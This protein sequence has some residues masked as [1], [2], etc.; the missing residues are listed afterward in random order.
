MADLTIS[1]AAALT[2]ANLASA[3]LFPVYDDSA[4]SG[5][6]GSKMTPVE[7]NIGLGRFAQEV[8]VASVASTPARNLT[9]TWFTG[10]SATTTKPHFLI[11]PAIGPYTT[12]TG[13]AATDVIT[14][15]GH[16][17]TNGN[18]VMFTSLTGGSGLSTNTGYYVINVSGSTLQLSLTSGGAAINFTT[19]ISA[20]TLV[21]ASNWST[22]GTG[23]G[24]NAPT[25]FT[26][27][28]F[29]FQ[30]NSVRS[31]CLYP[32]GNGTGFTVSDRVTTTAF[33]TLLGSNNLNSV[34]GGDGGAIRWA[35]GQNLDAW[36]SSGVLIQSDYF[37]GICSGSI[38]GASPDVRLYRDGA[39]IF[40]QRNGTNAQKFRV[41]GT[42][43]GSK[44]ATLEHD[45][46]TAKVSSSSGGLVIE[47]SGASL[48]FFGGTPVTKYSSSGGG[49]GISGFTGGGGTGVTDTDTFDGDMGVTT[50]TIGDLVR[51][52][53]N[54][55]LLEA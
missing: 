40:A 24:V 27:N 46:T 32:S 51:A 15:T 4:S 48:A 23:F 39:G 2:G 25:G 38:A 22:A 41:Y 10:G 7:L 8:G 17:L 12:I 3:D 44:Y 29:D 31:A 13:V 33:A 50:Y 9:G 20:A 11:E 18:G 47:E 54:Y 1:G 21:Q 26:G 6:K 36:S 49:G 52:L 37:F 5:S 43:S 19:D 35:M 53:K 45:G 16:T 14:I 55:N 34:K 28:Y 30:T 42:T